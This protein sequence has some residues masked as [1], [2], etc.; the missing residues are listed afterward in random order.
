MQRSPWFPQQLVGFL[1]AVWSSATET[2]AARMAVERAAEALDA[3]VAVI[4]SGDRVIA[5]V[6][7]PEGQVP[8]EEFSRLGPDG[9]AGQL[10]V[11][12]AG[13]ARV[14]SVAMHYPPGARL[15][16]ARAGPDGGLRQDEASLLQGMAR[17]TSMAMRT[18]RLLDAERAAREESDRHASE[19]ARL[20]TELTERQARLT[21]LAEEQTA[22]R[23]VATLVAAQAAPDRIFAAV[24]EEVGRLL[25]GDIG[26]VAMFGPDNCQT[27]MAVWSRTGGRFPLP[28][29]TPIKLEA[30]S[31]GAVVLWTGRP[32]RIGTYGGVS[33]Q[34]ATL[35]AELG[36][37][38]AVGA[39][40]LVGGRTWGVIS[41]ASSRPEPLP[42][43]CEQRLADFTKLVT[44]AISNAQ[45]RT[46]LAKLADE[47]AALRRVATLVATGVAPDELFDA[48]ITE[49]RLLLN[50]GGAVMLHYEADG[51]ATVVAASSEPGTEAP[52]AT[53]VT[54]D[55]VSVAAAVR[56][57]GRTAR[58]DGF[59]GPPGSIAAE[60]RALGMRSAAGA[61][62]TVEGSLWGAIVAAWKDT[63]L[64]PPDAEGRIA[65]FTQLVA[66]AI[67]N[68][69]S[70]AQLAAS[71][72]RIVATADE[73][74]RRIERN[75]HDGIQQ[76][77]VTLTLELRGLRDSVPAGED[78]LL[79][80]L[81]QAGDEL[82]SILDELREISRGVH[83][84][85]LSQGGL[86]PALRSL[87]RR[88]SV[89]VSLDIGDIGRL[90]QSLE[91]AAY[92]V[93]SEALANAAKHANAT[94]VHVALGVTDA[95][96]HLSISDDGAGGADPAKGT[97]II[98]LIDRVDAL[99]GKLTLDSPP[100][101]GTSLLIALPLGPA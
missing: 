39:P 2:T 85:V 82:V 17:V 61:P 22:L 90:P 29:G 1:E 67:S 53:R 91:A 13:P 78:T 23:R 43:N 49:M 64:V 60:Y 71:R 92:Y 72:A 28:I 46:E 37:R 8:L 31:L 65:Q 80:P 58:I 68:A 3:E 10:T 96:L 25:R 73:T 74:R 48:V 51:T 89:P 81:T 94:V 79:V 42:A 36:L 26:T 6:G 77:L 14:A 24:A 101:A 69:S 56:S 86:G 16:V 70:R 19:N 97:G 20:L 33:Y 66:T 35:R 57:T 55:G 98:G 11:P 15:V 93:V 34:V 63:Q 62:I 99:G 21:E 41:V 4:V 32:A 87:A 27:L 5:A 95:W 84:A 54:L 75:L 76:R 52:L 47:Q 59:G 18:Q 9:T 12:G 50:A 30:D 100:G 88:T 7:Y 83:P 40:I 45:A 38:S 44:T